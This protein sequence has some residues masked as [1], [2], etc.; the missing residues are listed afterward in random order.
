M[1]LIVA[2]RMGGVYLLWWEQD[3]IL[4]DERNAVFA[5]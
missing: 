1:T 5:Y 2:H 4:L 3:L